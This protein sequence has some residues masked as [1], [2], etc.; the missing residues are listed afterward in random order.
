MVRSTIDAFKAQVKADFA[1]PN[2]FEVKLRFPGALDLGDSAN[3]LTRLGKFTV[4]AA[5]LPSSQMGVIEVPYRGRVLKIAGDRTFEPWT[6]TIMNDTK[7]SLRGAFET[8]FSAIQANNENY[9]SLGTLGDASD[10][11]GYFADMQVSQLSR[12]SKLSGASA[13]QEAGEKSPAILRKYEFVNVFP[14]NIS[15]IDLD[16]GSNDAIEE[17]TVEFQVQYWKQVGTGKDGGGID[18]D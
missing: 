9:T 3:Q 8:W 17:F 2:L 10:E 15:A 1:R 5:N 16:F 7:F 11:T 4:R 12:D 6:V 18:E 13:S 14:S